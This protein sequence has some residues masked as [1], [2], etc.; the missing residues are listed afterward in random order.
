MHR[1]H[2]HTRSRCSP[3]A[4]R[5]R[6][7]VLRDGVEALGAGGTPEA[8]ATSG[9]AAY[10]DGSPLRGGPG[11]GVA[12]VTSTASGTGPSR[13]RHTGQASPYRHKCSLPV[14]NHAGRR[15]K[16]RGRSPGPGEG[17][18]C[19]AVRQ[20][21]LCLGVSHRPLSQRPARPSA[22]PTLPYPTGWGTRRKPGCT[23]P[24][25]MKRHLD[26]VRD[27][28]PITNQP[29]STE[30]PTIFLSGHT[31]VDGGLYQPL[32]TVVAL[33]PE[34]KGCGASLP[35]WGATRQHACALSRGHSRSC[36]F[37]PRCVQMVMIDDGRSSGREIF[38]DRMCRKSKQL[39]MIT[40]YVV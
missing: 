1:R 8:L 25:S 4:P 10:P 21:R 13:W 37:L 32:S 30:A 20:R 38:D 31:V 28:T 12:I 39:L 19:T 35:S 33:V 29:R 9:L 24:Y 5:G 34:K 22:S 17:H 11:G 16:G 2:G 26:L 36:A 7:G 23:G 6:L 14:R 27:T 3:F 40:L 18:Q 15:G